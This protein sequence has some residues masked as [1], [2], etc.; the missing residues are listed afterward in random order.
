[1]RAVAGRL[2]ALLERT[3]QHLA[4]ALLQ[5][6]DFNGVVSALKAAGYGGVV[7]RVPTRPLLADIARTVLTERERDVLAALSE[8]ATLGGIASRLTVSQN[9]VKT[10]LRSIYRKLG[11]SNREDAIAVAI[12]QH[13][14]IERD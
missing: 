6:R 4:V 8:G 9:T 3:E 5:P 14:L 2:G 11:V 7:E 1:V 13:L 12:D 10:Q